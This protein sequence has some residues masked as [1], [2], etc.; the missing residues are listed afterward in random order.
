MY[1]SIHKIY[2]QLEFSLGAQDQVIVV[3]FKN[4]NN[5]SASEHLGLLNSCSNYIHPFKTIHIS[6]TNKEALLLS[7][8]F[9][10]QQYQLNYKLIL[11]PSLKK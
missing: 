11:I 7:Q 6:K 10:P 8:Y 1:S 9:F 5:N 3:L 2:K 4:I